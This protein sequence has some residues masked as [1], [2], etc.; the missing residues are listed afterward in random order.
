[1]VESLSELLWATLCEVGTREVP[2][3]RELELVREYLRIQELRFQDR[4]RVELS[5]DD[6]AERALVPPLLLQPL[7][8]NAIRH[9][10]ASVPNGG[11]VIVRAGREG[12]NVVLTVEDYGP[13]LKADPAPD[14]VGLANTRARLARLYGS[15]ARLEL[16]NRPGGG[17]RTS[18][19]LPYRTSVA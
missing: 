1:M 8:E 17:V 5:T 9:G 3:A 15:A 2:L 10:V 12:P 13:G 7:A 19:F 4:L 6:D 18:I 16:V 14:G 11:A